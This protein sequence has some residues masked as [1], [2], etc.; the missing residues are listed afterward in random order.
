M[1]IRHQTLCLAIGL[2]CIVKEILS[3]SS[4]QVTLSILNQK[5]I[6]SH[7]ILQNLDSVSERGVLP[8][9]PADLKLG[10]LAMGMYWKGLFR[11][12]EIISWGSFFLF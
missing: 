1:N 5:Q 3:D 10:I 6:L 8:M 7:S 9:Y 11:D 4:S 12:A 2:V